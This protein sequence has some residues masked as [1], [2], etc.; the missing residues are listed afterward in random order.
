MRLAAGTHR[1]PPVPRLTVLRSSSSNAIGSLEHLNVRT[2]SSWSASIPRRA[3]CPAAMPLRGQD[4]GLSV[5]ALLYADESFQEAEPAAIRSAKRGRPRENANCI[6]QTP[7]SSLSS[8]H[9]LSRNR[10][11]TSA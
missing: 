9:S 11:A 10:H 1:S 7:S 5:L 2:H 6:L 8:P 4:R 3:L